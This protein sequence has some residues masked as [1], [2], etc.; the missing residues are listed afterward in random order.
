MSV[1]ECG[2][3]LSTNHR[4]LKRVAHA[5]TQ[6]RVLDPVLHHAGRRPGWLE[7]VPEAARVPASTATTKATTPNARVRGVRAVG[8]RRVGVGSADMAGLPGRRRL[9]VYCSARIRSNERRQLA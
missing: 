9:L 5:A 3:E 7:P 1:G 2:F 4:V 6:Q 8:G